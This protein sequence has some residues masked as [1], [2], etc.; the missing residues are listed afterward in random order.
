MGANHERL[1]GQ[2]SIGYTPAKYVKTLTKVGGSHGG[3]GGIVGSTFDNEDALYGNADHPVLPGAGGNSPG[4]NFTGYGGH[5]GGLIH[6]EV[7]KDAVIHGTFN[8]TSLYG[9][10]HPPST[11]G[12]SSSA[13]GGA[14]Y[15]KARKL[16]FSESAKLFANACDSQGS[17]SR[18][19]GGGRIAIWRVYDMP[20]SVDVDTL[21]TDICNVKGG[22]SPSTNRASDGKPGTLVLGQLPRPGFQFIVK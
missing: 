10:E 17:E 4:G 11:I 21:K 6:L 20:G 19:G 2:T 15:L 8:A 14:I 16:Y 9:I 3:L 7:E 18:G 1:P 22:V 5:G 13:A 12:H